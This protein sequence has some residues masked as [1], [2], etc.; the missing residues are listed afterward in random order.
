MDINNFTIDIEELTIRGKTLKICKPA[1][2]EEIFEGDPFLEAEKFPLWFKIW[3]ASIILADYIATL[4]PPLEILEIGAGLGIPSLVAS[5]FGHKV[6]A[7]DIEELP[8]KFLEKSANENGLS[9]EIQKLDLFNPNLSQKL[10]VIMGAEIVF[11]KKFYGP[12]LKL[13][14]NY[15]KS[16]GVILLAHSSERKSSLIPFLYQA[17]SCFE[18]QTCIRRLRSN[19]ETFEIILNRLLLKN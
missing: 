14:M 5:A 18:I 7:T 11:K 6:L 8:L 1:K 15:L 2:L 12:L 10:D 19:E 4:S 3:E 17:Q 16:G 9:L 13:F